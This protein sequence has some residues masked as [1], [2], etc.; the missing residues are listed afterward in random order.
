MQQ[1][2]SGVIDPE[3]RLRY[4]LNTLPW[5]LAEASL[6]R[7][8]ALFVAGLGQLLLRATKDQRR[9]QLLDSS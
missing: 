3:P 1:I 8:G 5:D 6:S 9:P 2:C 4:P 7:P